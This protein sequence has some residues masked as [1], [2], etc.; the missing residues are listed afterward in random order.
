MKVTVTAANETPV[1]EFPPG[2]AMVPAAFKQ[3]LAQHLG[4]RPNER[5]YIVGRWITRAVPGQRRE[6]TTQRPITT[7]AQSRGY[8]LMSTAASAFAD[9]KEALIA[10]GASNVRQHPAPMPAMNVAWFDLP[11]D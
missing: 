6:P 11:K 2:A 1:P 9:L 3:L 8:W 7:L 10:A 5:K 4:M